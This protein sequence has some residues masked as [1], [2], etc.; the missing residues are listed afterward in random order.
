MEV[1]NSPGKPIPAAIPEHD[2]TKAKTKTK[3]KAMAGRDV[4]IFVVH[5]TVPRM[6]VV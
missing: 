1:G 4:L 5:T 3:T 2:G 6:F